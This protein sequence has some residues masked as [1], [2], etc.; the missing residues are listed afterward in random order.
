MS[1]TACAKPRRILSAYLMENKLVEYLDYLLEILLVELMV[2]LL[3]TLLDV[4][5]DLV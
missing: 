2:L 4:V 3:E 1:A 5:L